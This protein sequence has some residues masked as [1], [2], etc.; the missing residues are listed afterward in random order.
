MQRGRRIAFDY[1]DVRIGVAISDL[2]GMLATPHG[3]ILNQDGFLNELKALV[4]EYEP[5]YFAVG[6]PKHLSGAKS[7]KMDSVKEFIEVLRSEFSLPIHEIDERLSTVSAA[8]N[9]RASGK[10]SKESKSLIDAAAAATILEMALD[11]E[12]AGGLH[13]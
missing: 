9:L 5:I 2:S 1:G 6:M 10:N 12:K 8:R 3:I 4:T 7:Q 11:Q 13:E